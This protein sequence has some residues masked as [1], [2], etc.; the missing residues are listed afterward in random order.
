MNILT[1]IGGTH[2]RFGL[3][4]NGAPSR[5]RKYLAAD[6]PSF[7]AALGAYRDEEKIDKDFSLLVATAAHKGADGLWRFVS[8][9][10]W[11]IDFTAPGCRAA[12]IL[13]DFE[14]ATWGLAG[15]DES[16][17]EVL[18][19]GARAME[20]QPR[21]LAGPGTGL[22]LGFLIPLKSGAYHAQKTKGGHM[23]AAALSGEQAEIIRIVRGDKEICVYED[24]VS[25]RGLYNIYCA[26]CSLAGKTPKARD[27]MALFENL[28][29]AGE[30][31]RL[32]HEFFGL[33][34]A[35]AAVTANAYGGCYLTGGVLDRLAGQNLFNFVQFEKFFV[36][37][38]A[39][40]VKNALAG[41]KIVRL[42]APDL[43][44]KGLIAAAKQA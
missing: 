39:E 14:A 12:L 31:L 23:P 20:L 26:Q 37:N 13:N 21:L 2:V 40:A 43:A 25:G 30:A 18:K 27:A 6:F 32:F 4:E 24:L 42:N 16:A 41:T 3:E 38:G 8:Q 15:L 17:Q 9:N 7:A 35:N 36:I 11:A 34:A 33:F 28:S 1:D 44:L 19:P 29:G 22:G 10:S 5:V